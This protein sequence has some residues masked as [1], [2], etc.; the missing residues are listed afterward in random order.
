[1]Q[2]EAEAR[3]RIGLGSVYVGGGTK[4]RTESRGPLDVEAEGEARRREEGVV[5]GFCWG[6][7]EDGSSGL[8]CR[9][10]M[11]RTGGRAHDLVEFSTAVLLRRRSWSRRAAGCHSSMYL[12]RILYA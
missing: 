2:G 5:R 12:V 8:G 3:E 1:M 10:A 11:G 4:H 9:M 7:K 6:G